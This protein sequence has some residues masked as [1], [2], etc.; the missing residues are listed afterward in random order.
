MHSH[1]SHTS[2]SHHAKSTHAGRLII[3]LILNLIITAAQII[4]GLVSGSLALLSDALHN[5]SDSFASLISLIA[6]KI[7]QRKNTL[8]KTF[9]YKRIE[10][11]A[12]LLNTSILIGISILLFK[13]AY[14]RLLKPNPNLQTTLIIVL[15]VAGLIANAIAALALKSAASNNLNIRSAYLHLLGDAL[16]S[17]AVI[18]GGILMALFGIFWLDPVLTIVIGLYV[19]KESYGILKESVDILMG[20]VPREIDI[21]E[22]QKAV[23]SF[24]EIANLHHVHIWKLNDEEIHFSG[25]IDL[26]KDI[27]TSQMDSIRLKIE[28]ILQKE[29]HISHITIQIE[30]NCCE[31]K[32]IIQS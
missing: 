12:A 15:G 8:K 1:H 10:I 29:F 14:E 6:L 32:K 5:L 17:F 11:L 18:G 28:E 3:S 13:E 4:G 9:G 25:H 19:L 2:H 16:T 21:L 27:L 7:S 22:I 31:D 26:K 30:F 20:N 24:P 23:E